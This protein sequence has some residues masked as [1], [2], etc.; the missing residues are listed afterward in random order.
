M[1]LVPYD[2]KSDLRA[3]L[4]QFDHV[5]RGNGWGPDE[6]RMHLG[7][8]LR[9]VAA[10]ILTTLPPGAITLAGLRSALNNRFGIE[11]QSELVKTQFA[12][13]KRKPQES[14]GELA[15][16]IR[17]AVGSA[18]ADM[19]TSAQE[20]LAL[21]HFVQAPSDSDCGAQLAMWHPPTMSQA[22]DAT[23]SYEAARPLTQGVGGCRPVAI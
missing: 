11:Q 13:R 7:A 9:G 22:V 1:Q 5:C 8:A 15:H 18:Y 19:A 23:A 20:R 3:Y 17:R 10:E 4:A 12:N 21:D 16:D 14:I 2:G 6:G